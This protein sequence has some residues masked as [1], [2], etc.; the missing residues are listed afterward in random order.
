M[1]AKTKASE[2]AQDEDLVFEG[3]SVSKSGGAS[4]NIIIISITIIIII[5]ITII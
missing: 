2:L 5:I 4:H 3:A 1:C